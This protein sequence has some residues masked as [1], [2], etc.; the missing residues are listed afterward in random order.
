MRRIRAGESS[1]RRRGA[2]AGQEGGAG[3]AR[4]RVGE[5]G[6][7]QLPV[8]GAACWGVAG[9]KEVVDGEELGGGGMGDWRARANAV[10][11]IR[12]GRRGHWKG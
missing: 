12:K 7:T 10:S 9:S 3:E 6:E 4:R 1:G 2:G 11:R 8:G 5:A